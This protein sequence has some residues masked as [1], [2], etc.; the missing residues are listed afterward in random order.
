MLTVTHLVGFGAGGARILKQVTD[1]SGTTYIG[2]MAGGGGIGAA[3][4]GNTDQAF[5]ACAAEGSGGT[6]SAYVGKHWA[7]GLSKTIGRFI[8][9]D[10]NDEGH[11][12]SGV[13]VTLSLYGKNGAPSS[14]TDGTMLFMSP[15]QPYAGGSIGV[16]DTGTVNTIDVSNAYTRHW[17]T[18]TP[19]G[20]TGTLYIAE[21]IFYELV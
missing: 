12:S 20:A 18:V 4:D 7:G 8:A 2:D 14:P 5:S 1:Y 6:R 13:S 11:A 16:Y 10:P 19:I 17:V 21:V 3:F 15:S 9:Y